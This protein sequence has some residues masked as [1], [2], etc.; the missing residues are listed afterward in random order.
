MDGIFE[1]ATNVF[2]VVPIS[3]KEPHRYDKHGR[4]KP[5]FLED[6][7]RRQSSVKAMGAMTQEKPRESLSGAEAYEKAQSGSGRSSP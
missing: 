3:I 7:V 2:D 1:K 4:L 5:E 6:A